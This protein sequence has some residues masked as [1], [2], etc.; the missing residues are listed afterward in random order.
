MS[1]VRARYTSSTCYTQRR[2]EENRTYEFRFRQFNCDGGGKFLLIVV[3]VVLMTIT[4]MMIIMYVVM[5]IM[6]MTMMARK[7]APH[8]RLRVVALRVCLVADL[9]FA[10][11]WRGAVEVIHN[12]VM[13]VH[14]SFKQKQ[15]LR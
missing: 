14:Q 2:L 3:A 10:E 8:F 13:R 11:W 5:M 12:Q 7:R 9:V 15:R 4:M 6:M 1:S